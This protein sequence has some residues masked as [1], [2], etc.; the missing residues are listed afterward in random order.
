MWSNTSGYAFR[1]VLT[2]NNR[3]LYDGR[4]PNS[5]GNVGWVSGLRDRAGQGRPVFGKT[6]ST[7]ASGPERK[8]NPDEYIHR[9]KEITR[10]EVS[11]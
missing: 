11:Q 8:S 4:D 3:H 1:T 5:F 7:T 2:L 9:I 10:L 6:R